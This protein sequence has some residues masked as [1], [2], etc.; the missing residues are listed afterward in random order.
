MPEWT[1]RKGSPCA[2]LV[3]IYIGVATVEISMEVPQKAKNRII[4]NLASLPL[5]IYQKK[6]KTL[7]INKICV[8]MFTGTLFT[9]AKMW[10]QPKCS[11]E[12]E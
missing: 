9:I 11:L 2:L 10:R 6:M 12:G 5:G 8:S 1:W 4:T 3:R 7:I